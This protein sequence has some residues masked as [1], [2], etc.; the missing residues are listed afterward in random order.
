MPQGVRA[1][2]VLCGVDDSVAVGVGDVYVATVNRSAPAGTWIERSG[3]RE[4]K[5]DISRSLGVPLKTAA[6]QPS[7]PVRRGGTS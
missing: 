1:E 2:L 7:G 5:V 6:L 4:L 3:L